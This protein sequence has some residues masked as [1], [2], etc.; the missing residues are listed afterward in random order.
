MFNKDRTKRWVFPLQVFVFLQESEPMLS[1]TGKTITTLLHLQQCKNILETNNV[2]L[3]IPFIPYSNL[4]FKWKIL[5]KGEVTYQLSQE[6]NGSR[7]I[8]FSPLIV[9]VS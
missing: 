2:E 1:D 7:H 9:W 8:V 5:V 3:T 6:E 4:D